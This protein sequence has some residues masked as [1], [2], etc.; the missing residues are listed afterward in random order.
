VS[1][2]KVRAHADFSAQT[3]IF[4]PTPRLAAAFQSLWLT[5]MVENA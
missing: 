4:G 2:E 5:P 3:A 1:V